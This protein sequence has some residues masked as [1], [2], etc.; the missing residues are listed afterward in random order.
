MANHAFNAFLNDPDPAA[1][2]EE[3]LAFVGPRPEGFLHL[4]DYLVRNRETDS[5]NRLGSGLTYNGFSAPAFFLGPVY[6]FYRKMWLWGAGYVVGLLALAAYP[7]TSRADIGLGVAMA[8]FTR[9][10]YVSHAIR[11]ITA[12]RAQPTDDRQAF[13][14]TLAQTGGVS[15]AAGWISGILFAVAI[16]LAV[17][18]ALT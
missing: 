6:F 2:R 7:M 13:L 15:W 9:W 8:L 10:A 14:N 3:F 11:K 17:V 4:Y 16:A 12:L 1:R 5:G 18:Q